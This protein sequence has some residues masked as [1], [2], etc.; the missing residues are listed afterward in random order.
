MKAGFRGKP[1][2]ALANWTPTPPPPGNSQGLLS[3]PHR[4]EDQNFATSDC[5][6]MPS[7][8]AS[9]L[10]RSRATSS[11][12]RIFAGPSAEGLRHVPSAERTQGQEAS[13]GCNQG[14]DTDGREQAAIHPFLEDCYPL[15]KQALLRC[16]GEKA[17]RLRNGRNAALKNMDTPEI[18]DNRDKGRLATGNSEHLFFL[19]HQGPAENRAVLHLPVG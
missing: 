9:Q 6:P 19:H 14:R 2:L 3:Q 1:F 18:K 16:C 12:L 5:L 15:S 11:T 4:G 8:E 17:Q 13:C 7:A 10:F